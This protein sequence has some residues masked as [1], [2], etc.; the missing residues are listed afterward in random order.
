[1]SENSSSCQTIC[2][3]LHLNIDSKKAIWKTVEAISDLTGN[4]VVD[5][6]T[7]VSKRV[8]ENWE[9]RATKK[10]SNFFFYIVKKSLKS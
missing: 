4:K 5:K 9:L 10:N 2:Y 6:F 7:N 8:V 3:R 1:M